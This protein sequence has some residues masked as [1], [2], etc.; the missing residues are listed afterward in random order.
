M[1]SQIFRSIDRTSGKLTSILEDYQNCLFGLANEE[2]SLGIL[3]REFSKHDRTKAGEIMS[4]AGR[5]LVSSSHQRI[6][7]YMPLMRIFQEMETFHSRAINDTSNTVTKLENKRSQYRASLL[8]MKDVSEKLNPD[9]YKQLDEFRRVQNQVRSDKEAFDEIKMDIFQKIDLLMAS[10]SNLLNQILG[11][12]QEKLLQT[13]EKN[14]ETFGETEDLIQKVDIYEYEYKSLKQL[15]SLKLDEPLEVAQEASHLVEGQH[16]A[17]HPVESPHEASSEPETK[18]LIGLLDE[19]QN[20][21]LD[22]S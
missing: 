4:M 7:L 11:P 19:S 3:L 1:I 8:W 20:P 12:Y 18:D 22:W 14:A 16:E 9:V 10:R 15:N 6:Q 2:N 17:P 21:G 13:F 5:S